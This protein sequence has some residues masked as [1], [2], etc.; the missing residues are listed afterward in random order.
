MQTK[1]IQTCVFAAALVVGLLLLFPGHTGAVEYK[2][3]GLDRLISVTYDDGK[4]INYRY[5]PAGNI[6]LVWTGQPT[7]TK[8]TVPD[9]NFLSVAAPVPNPFNA[10]VR[11]DFEIRATQNVEVTIYDVRGRLV[12]R[13]VDEVFDAGMIQLVWDGRSS[14]GAAV[15]SGL[16]LTR[17]RTARQTADIRMVLVK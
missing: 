14:S 1:P 11:I 3:D 12:R 10:R 7:D 9:F 6:L 16:Y 13:L 4:Q 5:D 2:Y 8:E 17:I 15:A